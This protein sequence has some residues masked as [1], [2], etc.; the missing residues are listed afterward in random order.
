MRYS[1]MV[2]P[3][4][5]IRQGYTPEFIARLVGTVPVPRRSPKRNPNARKGR[6]ENETMASSTSLRVG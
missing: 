2:W 6:D 1:A 3:Y 5:G 4:G